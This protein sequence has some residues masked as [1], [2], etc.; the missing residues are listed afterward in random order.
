MSTETAKKVQASLKR[1]Y[2]RE[3]R[4][5]LYGVC[6]IALGMLF[7]S[8]L[9]ISI[10]SNGYTAFQQT[11]VK[12]DIDFDENIIDPEGNRSARSLMSADYGRLVKNA[13]S[14]EFPDVRVRTAKRKLY[15]LFSSGAAFQLQDMVKENPELIGTRQP[16]WVPADDD[17]DMLIKGHIER[18]V[19]ETARRLSS[20]S[21]GSTNS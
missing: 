2:A 10:I 7:V 18:E 9:F 4:F 3:R 11:Y 6:S 15:G 16:V 8:I 20:K 12:L 14:R 5:R 19:P 1:R 21:P 13:V 17:V